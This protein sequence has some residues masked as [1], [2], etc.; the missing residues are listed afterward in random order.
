M[1]RRGMVA[2]VILLHPC[3]EPLA[4]A[5]AQRIVVTKQYLRYAVTRLSAHWNVVWNLANEWHRGS[6]YSRDEM[7]ELGHYLHDI[8]PYGRLTACHHYGRFEFYDCAWADISS[9]QHRGL[10]HEV[11]RVILQNMGFGKPVIND[12]Y[13]YEGDNHSPPN[14]ADNVRHDHW[15]IAV[16]GGYATYGDKT[17][18]PKVAAYF[19]S[20]LQDAVG[21]AAPE[22]L[23]HLPPFMER[24]SYR[25][26]V[27]ADAFLSECDR[28]Q[29]FC[30]ANPGSEYV[31]Y[32]VVG[33][34]FNL[35]LTHVHGTLAASWYNPRTGEW[36]RADDILVAQSSE[37]LPETERGDHGWSGLTRRHVVRFR[38]PDEVNDWV[39]HL[40]KR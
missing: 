13:G 39:L 4:H 5:G 10:P 12:E 7:D 31:V 2:S 19:S 29:V 8:D 14:D 20:V 37:E 33:Q 21:T 9:L 17:K 1:G 25:K 6:V 3:D 34:P 38:P 35:N 36:I 22:M 26:M 15:A 16:A 18:G 40:R 11:H 24:T 27:P 32:L 30:L 28:D 23:R